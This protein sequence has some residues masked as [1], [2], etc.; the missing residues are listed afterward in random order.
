MKLNV[1]IL[2]A[3][4]KCKKLIW[5]EWEEMRLCWVVFVQLNFLSLQSFSI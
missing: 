4:L 1:S 5:D 2:W 3:L